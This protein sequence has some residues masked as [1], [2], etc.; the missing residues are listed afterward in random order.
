[1]TR[2]VRE[3]WV[4]LALSAIILAAA[5]F[6][7]VTLAQ[8]SLTPD[9]AVTAVGVLRPSFWA[10]MGQVASS[11]RNPPLYYALEWTWTH[12]FGTGV[13]S[14]RAP[15]AAF[16]TLT[17]PFAYLAGRELAS[18]RAGLIAALLVAFNP[19]LIWYSQTARSYALLVLAST[20]ALYFFA[21]V[22][23]SPDR[24]W[25]VCWALASALA[26]CSHY[27]GAFPFIAEAGW[28]LFRREWRPRALAATAA[29]ALVGLALVPLALWQESRHHSNP[30][31]KV[32]LADRVATTAVKFVAGEGPSAHTGLAGTQPIQRIAGIAGLVLLA[33]A[34]LLLLRNRS[35]G[36]RR[37]A[38]M[39]GSVAAVSLAIPFGLALAGFDLVD[40]RNLIVALVPLLLVGAIGFSSAGQRWGLAAAVPLVALFAVVQGAMVTELQLQRHDWRPLAQAIQDGRTTSVLVIP[41][42][43]AESVIAYYTGDA[44]QRLRPSALRQTVSTRRFDL[45]AKGPG[46]TQPITGLTRVIHGVVSGGM[47]ELTY[48]ARASSRITA[49]Q[50]RAV[51]GL[52]PERSLMIGLLPDSAAGVASSYTR[53][54]H[55]RRRDQLRPW[56]PQRRHPSRGSGARGRFAGARRRLETGAF[57]RHRPRPPGPGG[58]DRRPAPGNA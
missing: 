17:V 4:A 48:L 46:L 18:K 35:R 33:A 22:L 30:S 26:I 10:T 21:K 24:R 53:S 54:G 49:A 41:T 36:L 39:A 43:H 38:L 15:S 3:H 32:Q 29:V 34:L 51:R 31:L 40:P 52:L 8:Q 9:E 14:L 20:A 27:F 37:G 1:L 57:L 6:R 45:I 5:I 19:Y 7:F 13:F 25:L 11:E 47:D 44:A 50:V 42:H 2:V 28:L 12:F 58:V 23:R 56:R 16:G 55:D